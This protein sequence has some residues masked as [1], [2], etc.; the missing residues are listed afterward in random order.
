MS[1]VWRLIEVKQQPVEFIFSFCP[2]HNIKVH[3]SK[4]KVKEN[5]LK[6]LEKALS[7]RHCTQH[8]FS[9]TLS[10]TNELQVFLVEIHQNNQII[11]IVSKLKATTSALL[12]LYCLVVILARVASS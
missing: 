7:V 11:S 1:S 3:L 2:F 6:L 5:T 12:Q 4:K 10:P 8:L 9:E